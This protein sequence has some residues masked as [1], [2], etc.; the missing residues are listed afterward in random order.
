MSTEYI[1]LEV[2]KTRVRVILDVV[3]PLEMVSTPKETVTFT[4]KVADLK[5]AAE[6]LADESTQ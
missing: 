3:T 2:P 5:K 4:L 1:K 6:A